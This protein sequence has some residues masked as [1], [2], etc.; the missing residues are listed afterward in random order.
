MKEHLPGLLS[1][2][3]TPIAAAALAAR[4]ASVKWHLLVITSSKSFRS[5]PFCGDSLRRADRDHVRFRVETIVSRFS[6]E[7][8]TVAAQ[9]RRDASDLAR[10]C[11]ITTVISGEMRAAASLI[12]RRLA[13]RRKASSS[14]AV[15]RGKIAVPLWPSSSSPV[16]FI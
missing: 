3:S 4:E 6:A 5:E 15:R 13:T 2:R 12:N 9:R 11:L 8:R 16:S 14:W 1:P 7:A 10:K